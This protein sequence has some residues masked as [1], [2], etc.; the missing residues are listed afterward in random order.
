LIAEGAQVVGYDPRALAN[1][2][3]ELPGLETAQGPY[4]AA[5]QAH[6]VVICTDWPDFRDLDL[7]RLKVAMIEPVIVDGRN[8]LDEEAVRSAGFRYFPTG[9]RAIT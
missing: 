8:L 4:E 9:R 7:Q 2:K 3:E 6:C 5:D 1:A